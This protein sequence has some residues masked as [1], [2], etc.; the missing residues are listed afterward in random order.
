M[1]VHWK[2]L[3]IVTKLRDKQKGKTYS[4]Q[5]N[6][7]QDYIGYHQI[8]IVLGSINKNF[9]YY[10]YKNNCDYAHQEIFWSLSRNFLSI[11]EEKTE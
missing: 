5:L 7:N 6:Q 9:D 4:Q 10:V 11:Y 8:T 3:K 1:H 2:G